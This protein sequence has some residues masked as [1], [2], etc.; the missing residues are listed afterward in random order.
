MGSRRKCEELILQGRIS[1][2]KTPIH[3]LHTVVLEG[4]EVR[5]DGAVIKPEEIVYIV[6]NKPAGVV[7]TLSDPENRRHIGQVFSELPFIKPVGRLDL[8]STGVL[9]LTNDGELTYR[10]THPKYQIRKSYRAQLDEKV[11]DDLRSLTRGGVQLDDGKLAHCK[12]VNVYEVD[13]KA[14]VILELREGMN[15][16][17]RRIFEVLG[18]RVRKLD[19]IEFAGIGYYGLPRGKWRYLTAEEVIK[20]RKMCGLL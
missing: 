20:L 17:V 1:I 15:R 2:N 11:R 7:T 6:Y 8:D 5:F 19:R 14:N 3:E 13:G 12:I 16:E 10:L 4:D 9:L 18:Y